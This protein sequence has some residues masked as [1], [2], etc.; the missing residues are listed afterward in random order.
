MTFE[1]FISP[2]IPLFKSVTKN[3]GLNYDDSEDVIQDTTISLWKKFSADKIDLSKNTT[4][5]AVQ[6]VNWRS[7]DLLDKKKR[8]TET[9]STI[10]EDN[11]LD[12][13]PDREKAPKKRFPIEIFRYASKVLKPRDYE[14]FSD[15]FIH[16]KKTNETAAK[17]GIDNAAVH[18]IRC[19]SLKKIK[20]YKK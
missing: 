11:N 12:T 10:G 17:F 14:I 8:H 6:L 18:V 2:L 1:E 7:K 3:H 5:Y 15:H 13:L 16:G 9:F 4:A 20:Q 19:R